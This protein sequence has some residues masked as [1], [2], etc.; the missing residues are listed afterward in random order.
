MEYMPTIEEFA[1]WFGVSQRTV[2]NWINNGDVVAYRVGKRLIRIDP[3]SAD[4]ICKPV[5]YQGRVSNNRKKVRDTS[6]PHMSTHI[7][8]ETLKR[9]APKTGKSAEPRGKSG[10]GC[11]SNS[12]V[13]IATQ[14]QWNAGDEK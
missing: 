5:Q 9:K 12:S 11:A 8:T 7:D 14:V 13:P 1:E 3:R 6:N 10:L 4:L 2:R